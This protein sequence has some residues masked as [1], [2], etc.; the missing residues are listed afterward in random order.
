MKMLL[1]SILLVFVSFLSICNPVDRF[2]QLA[3]EYG[4]EITPQTVTILVERLPD[5]NGRIDKM[6]DGSLRIIIEDEFY[7]YYG[8]NSPQVERLVFYLLGH[9]VLGKP[10]GKGIMN[11]NRVYKPMKHKHLDK[12][13]NYDTPNSTRTPRS[14]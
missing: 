13:F 4:L 12:L 14:V 3:T 7:N 11:A 5:A 9:A 10:S 2:Y 1:I 8:Q 6:P